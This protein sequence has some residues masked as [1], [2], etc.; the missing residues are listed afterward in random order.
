MSVKTV[1][2]DCDQF[3]FCTFTCLRW[4]NLFTIT[5]TFDKVYQWFSIS[6]DKGYRIIAFVIM[7]NHVHFTL[8]TPKHISHLDKLVSNGKRFIAYEMVKRLVLQN[9][10]EILKVLAD[11]VVPSDLRRGKLHQVFKPSFDARIIYN[12]PMLFQKIN[13]I[14]HN[15][16]NK[17]WSL[18]DDY[19]KYEHSS[20]GFYEED[21]KYSFPLTH[22]AR[23]L[24]GDD[25]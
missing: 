14:H 16:V 13:Y 17:K 5:N 8:N 4:L 25:E 12:E 24:Y 19:V 9:E 20:A 18:V 2:P 10:K 15:P 21:K 7:P 3:F 22:Y 6:H 1:H 11:G 23:V